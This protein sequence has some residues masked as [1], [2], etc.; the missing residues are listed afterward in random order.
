MGT[1]YTIRIKE[2][3]LGQL[4]DGLRSRSEAWHDT[5]DY[6]ETGTTSQSN[7]AIEECNDANEA[8]NIAGHFDRII[9][10]IEAQVEMQKAPR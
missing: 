9:A 1:T 5:A 7:F 3:D 6:F 10:T 2:N 8:L 4:L